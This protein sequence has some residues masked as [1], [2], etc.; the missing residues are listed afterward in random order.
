MKQVSRRTFL[1]TMGVSIAAI[2]LSACGATPTATPV[3][4]TATKPPAPTA[5]P[6]TATTAAAAAAPTATKAPAVATNT[7]APA[8]AATAAPTA[9]AAAGP[10]RPNGDTGAPAWLLEGSGGIPMPIVKDKMTIT[11]WTP[12]SGNPAAS[13][14]SFAEIACYIEQEKRTNIHIEFQHPAVNQDREA[15]NLMLASRKFPDVIE[16]NWISNDI[17]PGGP[18][19]AIADGVILKLNSLVDQYAPNFKNCL[20]KNPDWRKQFV[21]DSGEIY[22]FP[23]FRGDKQLLIFV[24]PTVREDWIK[25]LNIPVPETIDDWHNML[26][27]FKTKDPNGNGKA[28]ESA[29]TPAWGTNFSG[30]TF[31]FWTGHAF[32]SAFGTD[33][34]F[35]QV[36]NVVKY[37]PLDPQFKDFLKVMAAWY[38]EGLID[39]D[40][41]N[42][43]TKLRDAKITG[44]TLGSWV[45]YTGSGIGY[46][47]GL[48][49]GKEPASFK[50]LGTPYP[51]LKKGDPVHLAQKDANSPGGNTAAITTAAKNVK[52]IMQLLDYAFSYDGHNLFNFGVEGLSYNWVNGFPKYT[53]VVV[54]NPQYPLAVA[55]ARYFRS[56]FAGPF[57]QD[58]RYFGQYLTLPEQLAAVDTWSKPVNDY[59]MPPITPSTD[60]SKQFAKIMNDINTLYAESFT[61]V[62][63]GDQP[64]DSWDKTVTQMKQLG[65]DDAVKIQQAALDRY[66]KR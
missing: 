21:T 24:G 11:Y 17:Y 27:A 60:E 33:M 4:P 34:N 9:A 59:W 64:V 36:N 12:F 8:A 37:G 39:Q 22:G 53:D 47:A 55:M 10:K 45:A 66:N 5:V 38:K 35:Y 6:P 16:Y 56:N 49:A 32:V 3:P 23:F 63:N 43:D 51:V 13:M 54:K 20:L 7:P 19:K 46:F 25:K 1:S 18:S 30:Q 58:L 15:F 40:W 61:K 14:K 44:S 48:M 50:L 52:E 42:F 29:F 28:D 26:V 41:V 65:I 31:A 62:V 2:A 57:V